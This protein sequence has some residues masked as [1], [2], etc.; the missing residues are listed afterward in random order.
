[1]NLYPR[2]RTLSSNIRAFFHD[3]KKAVIC[4]SVV[5]A[6]GIVIGIVAAIETRRGVFERFEIE[7]IEYGAVRMFF[8]TSLILA[9]A[10]ALI[11]IA[12]S[13]SK[14]VFLAVIPFFALGFMFGEYMCVLVGCYGVIGVLNL[15]FIYL[16]FYIMTFLCLLVAASYILSHPGC[17]ASGCGTPFKLKPPFIFLLKM[18]GINVAVN[19]VIFL[20][21]GIF[22]KVIIVELF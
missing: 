18:Y 4:F 11:W 9:G 3:N 15:I 2:L 17:G 19:A 1:M 7:V 16:P 10:Y 14:V 8:L 22:V 12:S 5:F 21:V 20:I 13:G 6:L